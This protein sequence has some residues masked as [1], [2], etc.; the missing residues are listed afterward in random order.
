MSRYSQTKINNYISEIHALQLDESWTYHFQ[1]RTTKRFKYSIPTIVWFTNISKMPSGFFKFRTVIWSQGMWGP[2][3]FLHRLQW[4][5]IK[6]ILKNQQW[7]F[8]LYFEWNRIMNSNRGNSWLFVLSCEQD[9]PLLFWW[10]FSLFDHVWKVDK[11][12]YIFWLHLWYLHV[13]CMYDFLFQLDIEVHFVIQNIWF[14]CW[15]GSFVNGSFWK[16]RSK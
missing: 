4:K 7:I 6:S 8:K 12:I 5:I 11:L 2:M 9:G 10:S 14:P 15:F 13:H 16:R 1:L 3:R